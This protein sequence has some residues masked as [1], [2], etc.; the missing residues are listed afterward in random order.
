MLDGTAGPIS[1][2]RGRPRILS[3]A[4]KIVINIVYG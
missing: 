4:L 3:Y 1:E 2:G